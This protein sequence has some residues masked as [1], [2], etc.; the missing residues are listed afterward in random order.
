MKKAVDFAYEQG[1]SR[2]EM[3]ITEDRRFCSTASIIKTTFLLIA[4]EQSVRT[5]ELISRP[6]NMQ[7]R[8]LPSL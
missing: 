6:R 2:T 5:K 8:C 7:R 3:N 4:S 1:L